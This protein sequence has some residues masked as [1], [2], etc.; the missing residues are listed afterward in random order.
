[1]SAT[2]IGG[3]RVRRKEDF[4]FIGGKVRYNGRRAGPSG[5][6]AASTSSVRRTRTQK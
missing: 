6:D 2:W 5:A 1:M 4:S 3:L